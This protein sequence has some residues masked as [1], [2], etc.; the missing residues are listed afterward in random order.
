MKRFL[1]LIAICLIL[2]NVNAQKWDSFNDVSEYY[3]FTEKI[4]K[5]VREANSYDEYGK[6]IDRV[7]RDQRFE[8]SKIAYVMDETNSPF[9]IFEYM[10]SYENGWISTD[11]LILADSKVLPDAITTANKNRFE[12]KWLPTWHNAILNASRR[13]EEFSGEYAGYYDGSEED[14]LT[15]LCNIIFKNTILIFE[16]SMAHTVF[17]I[18]DIRQKNN[19]YYV[20]C[21]LDRSVQ[22]H[23]NEWYKLESFNN[24]PDLRVRQ[25]ALFIIEP[26][27]NRIRFYNGENYKLIIEL[28]QTN[29]EWADS[30]VKYIKSEYKNK[31]ANLKVIEEKLEHPWSNPVTGLYDTS[32]RSGEAAAFSNAVLKKTMS[33]KENLKLRSG[34]ATTTSVLAVMSA[35]TRVKILTLGKQATI[36]G[37]TSNGVQ[38]EVQAGAKD[39]DG[40][41][42]AA[43]TTGWC[44][45]GYL[46]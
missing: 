21:E 32:V 15:G 12:K 26:N 35:G 30:M 11:D 8:S 13:L 18:K 42:I 29:Q 4:Y 37:I 45:G 40:K 22:S 7:N 38:V 36:D 9:D 3:K 31:P 25:D 16:T 27:G 1:F 24:L 46:E 5:T 39:R 28:M 19:V 6:I 41:A 2:T 20:N 10:I 14:S 34:E 33:V 43:G 23:F 44:F 17:S